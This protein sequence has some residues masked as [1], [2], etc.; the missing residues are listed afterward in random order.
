MDQPP[1]IPNP[2]GA[3]VL[4]RMSLAARLLNVFAIPG[5]VFEDLRTAPRS[6][7]NWLAPVLIVTAI[8]MLTV[9]SVAKPPLI[10]EFLQSQRKNYDALVDANKIKRAEAD[11]MLTLLRTLSQP[12]A[13]KIGGTL[14]FFVIGM[15]RVC[16]WAFVLWMLAL[17]FLK[18]RLDFFKTLEIAGLATMI[19]ALSLFVNFLLA[20]D[21]G[22]DA[23]L[24]WSE[25]QARGSTPL[26]LILANVFSVWFVGLLANGLAR[27]S[28]VL[29][30]RTFLLVLGCWIML[31][32]FLA[33]LLLGG[34]AL[35]K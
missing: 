26:L 12:A 35:V 3:A 28:G 5:E 21:F 11:Q 23:P 7:A 25:I 27:L 33:L 20:V 29:F 14:A 19:T 4:P 1:P 32:T 15:L 30:A 2:S 8:G 18:V 6:F 16:G 31:Q 13:I 24:A 34:G 17:V 22:S 9:L 10:E